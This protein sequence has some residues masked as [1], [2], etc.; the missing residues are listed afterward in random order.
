MIRYFLFIAALT[1]ST[2]AFCDGLVFHL[3]SHHSFGNHTESKDSIDE[4][5]NKKHEE[6]SGFNNNNFGLGYKTDDGY[7]IGGYRNS[8]FRSTFYFGKDMMANKY[9]GIFIMGSI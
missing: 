7:A 8:Q 6:W 5:G 2:S 3:Q 4:H 1:I 9:L